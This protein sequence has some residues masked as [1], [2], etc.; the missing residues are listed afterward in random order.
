MGRRSICCV[1]H[2]V[3]HWERGPERRPVAAHAERDRGPHVVERDA[4]GYRLEADTNELS[5]HVEA[6]PLPRKAAVDDDANTQRGL[7]QFF[8]KTILIQSPSRQE[9]PEG[10]RLHVRAVE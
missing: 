4:V 1:C 6:Q 5:V 10:P 7:T 2:W 8:G 9:G 3:Y